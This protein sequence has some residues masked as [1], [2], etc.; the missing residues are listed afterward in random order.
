MPVSN[1]TS[2]YIGGQMTRLSDSTAL[3]VIDVNGDTITLQT[4]GDKTLDETFWT[5]Y[6]LLSYGS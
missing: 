6:E 2:D 3:N 5:N 1:P 4:D